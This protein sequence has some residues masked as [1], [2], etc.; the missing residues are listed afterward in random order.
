MAVPTH[1]YTIVGWRAWYWVDGK[2]VRYQSDSAEWSHLPPTGCLGY[3]TYARTRP[4]RNIRCG[5]TWYWHDPETLV[6]GADDTADAVF[7]P[8][9]DKA[10][11]V[12]RGQ[13]IE[14]NAWRAVAEEMRDATAA[15]DESLRVDKQRA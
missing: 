15:P 13:W 10:A 9:L 5:V 11:W 4:Y 1:D 8:G 3:V 6:W 14:E 12:K 2:V 7:R